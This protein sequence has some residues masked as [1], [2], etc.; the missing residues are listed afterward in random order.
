M[1]NNSSF[2]AASGQPSVITSVSD[3][4]PRKSEGGDKWFVFDTRFRFG[5]TLLS[6]SAAALAM[7]LSAGSQDG[8]VWNGGWRAWDP[9]AGAKEKSQMLLEEKQ[10]REWCF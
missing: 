7:V 2:E 8:V 1:N 6:Q 5:M 4:P 9:Y 10:E 3:L